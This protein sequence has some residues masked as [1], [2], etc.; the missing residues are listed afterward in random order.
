MGP[1]RSTGAMP[2]EGEG[3]VPDLAP[4]SVGE[5]VSGLQKLDRGL[6]SLMMLTA[7]SC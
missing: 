3:V 6:R 5:V 2:R 1:A 7:G 4:A